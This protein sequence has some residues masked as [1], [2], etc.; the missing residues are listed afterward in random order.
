MWQDKA[1]FI[2]IDPEN[3]DKEFERIKKW[4]LINDNPSVSGIFL[5][6][7]TLNKDYSKEIIQEFK[8]LSQ[9]PIIGFPGG[10]KQVFKGL[11]HLLF[12]NYLNSDMALLTRTKPIR[13]IS[14]LD[15]Y[16]IETTPTAYIVINSTHEFSTLEVTHSKAI[17]PSDK[18]EIETRIK[19]SERMGQT[20]LYL[21][22]GSGSNKGIDLGL[23]SWI[24]S[25]SKQYIIVG[26]GLKN[27]ED[28]KLA[29][30]AGANAVVVGT[31]VEKKPELLETLNPQA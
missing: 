22:A 24:R 28:L 27:N 2:L 20:H 29:F 7:S 21:E 16:G 6:G 11:D 8:A 30:E 25:F 9:K 1:L 15:S 17:L 4:R 18:R 13:A 12:L 26:G 10:D 19:F 5:G 31:A 14:A 23:I 3:E